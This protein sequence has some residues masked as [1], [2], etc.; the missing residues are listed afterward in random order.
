[1]IEQGTDEW[2]AARIGKVTASRVADVIAKTKTGYSS[3]R[4]NYMAQLICE[5]LTN[6]KADGFTN[7]AMQWGTE[8]EPLA[9]LSYEVSQNVLVDEVG[10]VPHPRILM[11]GA[12]PD[13]LV[14][15]NGL[16]EIKCP[17][18]ATHIDTLLSETV[19]GKYNTQMQ[20]QMACTDREWCDF[21]SFDNRL[22]TELQLF[23]KRVPR[24]NVFIR[25]IEGEIV[26][27]IAELDDKIN[28][29]M[30]VKNV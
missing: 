7:A 22:P 13:G 4:D 28:K 18:T 14:G 2:F 10:F 11:A 16:L 30:K 27:F 5:R 29:L 21:V 25:L 9:R 20:F 15:D 17:N 6:Q 19:P 8:T 12:S 24:D 1:M 23:V 26:Q 3:S